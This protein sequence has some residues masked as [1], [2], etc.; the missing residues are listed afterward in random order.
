ME[1][2]GKISDTAD[3]NKLSEAQKTELEVY[4]RVRKEPF[5]HHHLVNSL[6]YFTERIDEYNHTD[7]FSQYGVKEVSFKFKCL[8]FQLEH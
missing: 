6:K 5:F 1:S 7:Y 3:L 8:Y 2:E 4:R